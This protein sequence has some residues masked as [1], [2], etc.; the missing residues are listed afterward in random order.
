MSRK[1]AIADPFANITPIDE[2]TLIERSQL[3]DAIVDDDPFAMRQIKSL[4]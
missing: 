1:N 2:S 3:L 4:P